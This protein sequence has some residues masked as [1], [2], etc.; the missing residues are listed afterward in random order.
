MNIINSIIF[1]TIGAGATIFTL[2]PILI[3]IKF[4]IPFT[5]TL[6]K[7][8]V[9]N[10]NNGIIKGYLFSLLILFIFFLATLFITLFFFPAGLLGLLIGGSTALLFSLGK[11]GENESNVSDYFK[12]NEQH[13]NKTEV[14][15]LHDQALS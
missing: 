2:I 15:K 13:L 12:T 1:F 10:Q 14:D 7:K 8:K 11:L 5:K 6:E 9:L 4:G 3:I